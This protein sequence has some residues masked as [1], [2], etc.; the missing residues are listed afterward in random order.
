MTKNMST[1]YQLS[2]YLRKS[3]SNK[4][5][6]SDIYVRISVDNK[7]SAMTINRKVDPRKWHSKS[8]KMLGKSPEAIELNNYINVIKNR[9]KNIHQELIEKKK[10]YFFKKHT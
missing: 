4:S 8:E 6:E 9:I 10:I 3:R 1:S 7:R 2:F 5:S